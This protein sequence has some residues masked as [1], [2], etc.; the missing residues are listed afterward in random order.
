MG[1]GDLP[2]LEDGKWDL[3]LC[4]GTG[5]YETKTIENGNGI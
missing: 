2:F 5:I 4:T 1:C 3:I